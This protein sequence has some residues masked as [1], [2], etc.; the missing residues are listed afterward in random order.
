MVCVCVY[1]YVV[2]FLFF[3]FFIAISNSHLFKR[4]I[5]SSDKLTLQSIKLM[6]RSRLDSI[7]SS[8]SNS[9]DEPYITGN[10]TLRGGLKK[11]KILNLFD[12]NRQSESLMKESNIFTNDDGKKWDWEIIITLL[13]KVSGNH[14]TR[15][16]F[17]SLHLALYFCINRSIQ[18]LN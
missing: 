18:Q 11:K 4:E 3:I 9:G 17:N 10:I 13:S 15:L 8:T 16:W 14:N 5:E 1:G 2:N 7:G 6:E 12:G